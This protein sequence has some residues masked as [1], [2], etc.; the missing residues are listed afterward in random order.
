MAE[1]IIIGGGAAGLFAAGT[2]QGNG[3]AVTIVEHMEETGKKLLLTG[4]G[5]C[6]VTNHCDEE[7]FLRHVR[8]NPRFLYSSLY[9]LP[10]RDVMAFFEK[11][12]VPLKTERGRRVFPQSDKAEDIRDALRGYAKAA[13]LCY[14]QAAE[15]MTEN[16][17]ACGVKLA[18]GRQLRGDAVLLATGGL[19]YPAT[20]STGDG[21]RMAKRL[22]HTIIAP[23]P[24]L[25]P[26]TAADD[27][28]RRMMGLSLKNVSLKLLENGKAVFQEQGELLFAHFGLSGPL[29]LSASAHM[30]DTSGR[31]YTAE[32]D[33]KPALDMQQLD[34]RLLRDFEAFSNREACNAL[35]KLLPRKSIPV[36]LQRWGVDP[37]RKVNQLTREER[38][39]LA[40]L[41]KAFP[42]LIK[43][44]EPVE[45]AVITSGGVSVK[46][47]DPKTMQSK[48]VPGLYFAGEIL[49]VDAYTGGY[50]LQIAF[51]T[52]YAAASHVQ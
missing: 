27:T 19:S 14:A 23:A 48:L 31:N 15:I 6:N 43:G 30:E 16:G 25:V 35:E 51:C 24:S 1:L 21:Y 13:R 40:A 17:A 9:A 49:D 8:R 12:G 20:G 18:N 7:T 22:G 44:K 28:C 5:R 52:A 50:N 38:E 4:K 47:V 29:V 46:E 33:W 2:A 39:R 11:R 26:L 10:P 34:K 42:I 41:I 32:I 36:F 45:R 37:Q 3:H